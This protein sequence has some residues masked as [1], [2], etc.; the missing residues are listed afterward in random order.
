ME[1]IIVNNK[2]VTVPDEIILEYL[3]YRKLNN[4]D[5]YIGMEETL[6]MYLQNIMIWANNYAGLDTTF[7]RI[8]IELVKLANELI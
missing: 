8:E 6:D 4:S 2:F 7:P 1:T 3:R 5:Y